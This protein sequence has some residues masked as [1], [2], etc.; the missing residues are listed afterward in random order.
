MKLILLKKLVV[1][2]NKMN[3]NVMKLFILIFTLF[4]TACSSNHN[5]S[6]EKVAWEH[7]PELA[8]LQAIS[9]IK[10]FNNSC[11]LTQKQKNK[12]LFMVNDMK[13][14]LNRLY[15]DNVEKLKFHE[16]YINAA[17]KHYSKNYNR[18]ICLNRVK[19]LENFKY[20]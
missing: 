9:Q 10:A 3:G 12:T 13:N 15:S 11:S 8:N 6:F 20:L 18:K 7:N 19:D 2:F 4:L 5:F 1:G 16:S 14:N 17:T